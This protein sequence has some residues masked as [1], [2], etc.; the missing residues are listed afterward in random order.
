M[1]AEFDPWDICLQ[2][3]NRGLLARPAKSDIVRLTPP[4]VIN[5]RE[6]RDSVAIIR[7]TVNSYIK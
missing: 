4:L 5:E 6:M 1:S 2:L 3:R 7:N